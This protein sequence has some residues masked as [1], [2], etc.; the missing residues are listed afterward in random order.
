MEGNLLRVGKYNKQFND[1]LGINIAELEIFRSKGLPTHMIKSRHYKAL[2]YIDYIP[3]IIKSP[4]YIGVNPNEKGV[5]SIELIKRY[6]DNI[7]IGIKLDSD[8]EYLYVS[9]M[10]DVQ[11][12]KIQRRL[13]SGRL[14]AFIVDNEEN[15]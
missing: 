9:T 12:G 15:K 7:L 10:H 1:L 2:K 14:K 4:D 5:K 6:A 11:E 3:D 13:H 8:N